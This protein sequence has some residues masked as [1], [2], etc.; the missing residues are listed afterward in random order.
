[1]TVFSYLG[2][3]AEAG[4]KLVRTFVDKDSSMARDV[5]PDETDRRVS[6][7]ESCPGRWQKASTNLGQD[8]HGVSGKDDKVSMRKR[9]EK[10]LTPSVPEELFELALGWSKFQR[11]PRIGL[12]M[13]VDRA[14][15]GLSFGTGP[16]ILCQSCAVWRL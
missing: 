16:G 12:A 1:M 10:A 2:R 11:A 3:V 13:L 5:G 14:H 7:S 15:H 4:S 9:A 8:N 6:G